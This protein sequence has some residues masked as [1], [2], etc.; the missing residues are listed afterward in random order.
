MTSGFDSVSGVVPGAPGA[1]AS[2]PSTWKGVRFAGRDPQSTSFPA[3]ARIVAST[4]DPLSEEAHGVWDAHV[5]PDSAAHIRCR[6][7][8][9]AQSSAVSRMPP[10]RR[11]L[12]RTLH[13]RQDAEL[14]Q[15]RRAPLALSSRLGMRWGHRT[16]S[17][18]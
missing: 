10:N 15:Q 13:Q 14:G 11:G 18:R 17:Q 12:C 4:I 3:S 5:E 6:C 8:K 16:T 9:L 2:M 7:P 1:G